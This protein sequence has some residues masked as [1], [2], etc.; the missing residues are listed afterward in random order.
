MRAHLRAPSAQ[1]RPMESGFACR[2]EFQNAS[3]VCPD[4]VRPDRSVIVPEIITGSASMPASKLR[5]RP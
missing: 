2:S 5:R 3:G 1:F 4:R